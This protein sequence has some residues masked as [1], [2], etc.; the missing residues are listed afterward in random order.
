MKKRFV[1][2]IC[3]LFTVLFC[4][5]FY[6]PK[7]SSVTT[8][9]AAAAANEET[10]AKSPLEARFLNMLNHNF[11]YNDAFKSFD[12]LTDGCI[13]SMLSAKEGD[14]I[15]ETCLKGFAKD[16][17][18]IDIV[19]FAKTEGLPEKQGYVY[20]KPMGFTRFTHENATVTRNEDGTY[21]VITDVTVSPHDD[22]PTKETAISL[23]VPNTE[24]AFG[25]NI[26]NSTIT[27][28]SLSF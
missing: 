8:V 1:T 27:E 28:K 11:V 19:S 2:V 26:V 6:F 23:F 9:K 24:S 5:A 4:A 22:M 15:S 21:T 13:L 18:G 20:V 14:F 17:Y 16:M 7:N 3:A 12:D 10:A 25:Y